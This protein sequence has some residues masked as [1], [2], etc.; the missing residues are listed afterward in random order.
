MVS[1]MEKED[2]IFQTMNTVKVF[3]ISISVLDGYLKSNS[4]DFL[5]TD[6]LNNS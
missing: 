3:G 6:L 4:L 2:T 5:N 1:V